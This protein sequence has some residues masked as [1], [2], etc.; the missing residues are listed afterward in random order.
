MQTLIPE[1]RV[2]QANSSRL[3]RGLLACGVA[4]G[5][6]YIGVALIQAFTRPGFD[7]LRHDVSLLSNGDLGWIQIANFLVSG[8]LTMACALGMR[9]A[10]QSGP[11]SGWGALLV[12]VYG[13]GLIGAG[14]FTADPAQGF[15]PGA[16][17]QP[18]AISWHG[19]LHFVSAAPAFLALIAACFLF[20]R[21]FAR[22]GERKW[23]TFSVLTGISFFAGFSG[24]ASGSGQSWIIICFWIAL[25]LVWV[26]LA[27]VALR[28]INQLKLKENL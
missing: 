23:A 25:V 16:T 19:L 10:L 7:I 12:G 22:A 2:S 15:P 21:R 6:V 3:T 24:I 9:R 1:S 20:A 13:L 14:I 17:S 28:L 5:P 4:A 26:W 18:S 8:L 27:L 11:A